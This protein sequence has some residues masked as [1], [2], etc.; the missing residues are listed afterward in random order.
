MELTGQLSQGLEGTASYSFQE[1]KD[2]S[3]NQFLSNSP[4]NLAKLNL[5]QPL[6]RRKLFVSLN[7]QYRSRVETLSGAMVSPYSVV[8]LNV[9][10]H[11]IGSH[12]DLSAGIYNLLDKTYYDPPSSND[13]QE[14]IQQDGRTFRVK[15][16]WHI[17]EK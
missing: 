2:R 7:S 12:M 6:L 10:G 16:T 4:R 3:T 14:M 17:G 9:L 13:T 8:N 11:R 15:V 5:S 1:S